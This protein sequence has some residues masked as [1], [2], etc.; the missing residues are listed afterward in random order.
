VVRFIVVVSLVVG[1]RHLLIVGGLLVVLTELV[2]GAI[3]LGLAWRA[4]TVWLLL[5]L[6]SVSLAC[7]VDW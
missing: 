7:A 6:L 2:V 5:L 1:L 3:G 4:A